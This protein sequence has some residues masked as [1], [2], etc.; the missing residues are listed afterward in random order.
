M[1]TA[2]RLPSRKTIAIALA[3]PLLAYLLGGWLLLPRLLQSEAEQF[4]AEKTGHHLQH[5]EARFQSVSASP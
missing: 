3:I 4:I 2:M 1:M 5:G